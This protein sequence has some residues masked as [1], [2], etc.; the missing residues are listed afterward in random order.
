MGF[1]HF[2]PAEKSAHSGR[3]VS[4]ELGGHVSS[5]TLSAQQ[6]SRAGVAAHSSPSGDGFW[7]DE[8]GGMWMRLPTGWWMLLGSD[9]NV[10]WDEPCPTDPGADRGGGG[11]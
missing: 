1:S 8:A 10:C 6:V 3:Q 11:G 5:S 4:A 9:E 7:V 2:S